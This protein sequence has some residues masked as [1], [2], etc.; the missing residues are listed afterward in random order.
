MQ[1]MYFIEF[2]WKD[3]SNFTNGFPLQQTQ[4]LSFEALFTYRIEG[5]SILF[6][7]IICYKKMISSFLF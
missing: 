3:E 2:Y 1:S 5:A 7:D 6:A 4:F